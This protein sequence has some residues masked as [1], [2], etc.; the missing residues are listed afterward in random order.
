MIAPD[1]RIISL[2]AFA[3]RH[4]AGARKMSRDALIAW[5]TW[6][7]RHGYLGV[8]RAK[9]RIVGAAFVRP[10]ETIDEAHTAYKFSE[11][12]QIIWVDE[13]ASCHPQGIQYLFGHAIQRFG[14]R[15]TFAGWCLS[16]CGELR[17]LPWIAVQ[18]LA[19]TTTDNGLCE[20]PG[21]A[22]CARLRRG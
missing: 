11:T 5:V 19:M 18:R 10:I 22:G 12:G 21:T 16:R 17:M 9:G 13:I 3:K 14:P 6:Y 20:P 8:V 1:P 7:W 4:I 2:A 15:E